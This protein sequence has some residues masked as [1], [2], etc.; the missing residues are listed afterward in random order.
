MLLSINNLV[1]GAYWANDGKTWVTPLALPTAE[2]VNIQRT[3]DGNIEI[4][5]SNAY[6]GY[7]YTL[8]PSQVEELRRFLEPKQ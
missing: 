5:C 4:F 7:G 3:E 8:N 6:E 2:G 1:F